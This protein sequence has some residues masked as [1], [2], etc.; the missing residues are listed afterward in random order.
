MTKVNSEERFLDFGVK[1][2]FGTP[3]QYG[4]RVYGQATYG[5]KEIEWDRNEYGIPQYGKLIY[6][7]DDKRWGIY[8][9]RKENGRIFYVREEFYIPANPQSVPQQAWRTIFANGMTAWQALT[10]A[11][12][13]EY[14]KR[15]N[16][17]G[18][19][20]RNLFMKHYLNSNK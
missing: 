13:N 7:T 16:K 19:W 20:G 10:Q 2:L 1:G 18:M 8:Q 9:R 11:E 17:L 5:L 3:W 12:K 14:N 4:E 15:A 6:G